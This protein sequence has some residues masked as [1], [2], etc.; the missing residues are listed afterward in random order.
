VLER[1]LFNR[2]RSHLHNNSFVGAA[3][4]TSI[5]GRESGAAFYENEQVK[6]ESK[7]TAG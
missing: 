2:I 1:F 5:R 7:L 3:M 6:T 4:E